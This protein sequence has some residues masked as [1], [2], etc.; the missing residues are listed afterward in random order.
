MGS[1]RKNTEPLAELGNIVNQRSDVF[2]GH[3]GNNRD[4][5][6]RIMHRSIKD[7]I[8]HIEQA[9]LLLKHDEMY[10]RAEIIVILTLLD[11]VYQKLWRLERKEEG[12]EK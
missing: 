2:S 9:M 8:I 12:I 7:A 10:G 1:D 4:E 3:S 6:R 11:D 5:G